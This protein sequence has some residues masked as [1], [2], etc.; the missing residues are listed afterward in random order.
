MTVSWLKKGQEA[1][2]ELKKADAAAEARGADNVFR[3]WLPYDD[4]DSERRITFL[5]GGI[6]EDG[7][8]DIPM[9]YEHN[10]YMNGRWGNH[11]VCLAG[12]TS[13]P[14][15]EDGDSNAMLVGAATIV[16]HTPYIIKS[17]DRKGEEIK[18]Q[19]KLFVCPRGTVKLLHKIAK[20]RGGLAGVTLDV[21]RSGKKAARVGD[22]F[23][24]VA[25]T[26]MERIKEKLG[27]ETA[28]PF[29]YEEVLPYVPE[30]ELRNLGFGAAPVGKSG[31]SPSTTKA[32]KEK[33]AE[34]PSDDG[35]ADDGAGEDFDDPIPF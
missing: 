29:D 18:D 16:D 32:S 6:D 19:R 12:E 33:S 34:T 28:T 26:N 11:F 4:P 25:K 20:K 14:I 27:E 30:D 23:D 15:C 24:F 5:D 35:E 2:E 31:P 3:F 22:M 1:N 21:S 9:Y 13:C 17:G 8:L 10:V 7:M